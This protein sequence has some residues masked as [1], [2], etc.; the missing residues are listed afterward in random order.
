M[1]RKTLSPTPRGV[2]ER[3]YFPCRTLT[4]KSEHP[5]APK[6]S[7]SVVVKVLLPQKNRQVAVFC[8]QN[9]LHHLDINIHSR[10]KRKIGQRFNNFRVRIHNINQTFMN[11]HLKLF[12]CI[13]V[14]ES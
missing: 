7:E 4:E 2:A 5:L 11:S 10:G 6:E 12:S 13:F 14:N 8:G 9:P 1:R 3:E